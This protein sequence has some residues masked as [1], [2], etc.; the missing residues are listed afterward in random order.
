VI[1]VVLRKCRI[2]SIY[3]QIYYE[4]ST[5]KNQKTNK[6][7]ANKKQINKIT[8]QNKGKTINNI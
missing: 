2:D 3:S 6:Q 4:W 8:K 5:E 1:Q 7:I